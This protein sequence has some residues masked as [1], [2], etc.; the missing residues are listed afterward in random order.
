MVF[1]ALDIGNSAVKGGIFR[2]G[3]IEHI[4]HVDVVVTEP[5]SEAAV[6]TWTRALREHVSDVSVDRVGVASVVPEVAPVAE[7]A[8]RDL[9]GA[10]V[11][12]V[13][14]DADLPFRLAYETPQTLGADRLAAAAAGDDDVG[15]A[16]RRLHELDVHR[17]DG[18]F[19]LSEDALDG[20]A[21]VLDVAADATHQANVVGRVDVDLDVH[22]LFEL[23]LGQ[24]QDA[25]DDHDRPR[26]HGLGL[27]FAAVRGK[28]VDRLLDGLSVH[29]TIEVLPH[30]LGVERIG[31]IKVE[32]LALLRGMVGQVFVVGVVV[33]DRDLVGPKLV[34]DPV[35]HRRFARP[36]P[37]GNS[38][39]NGGMHGARLVSDVCENDDTMACNTMACKSM[40]CR[41]MACEREI[42]N[43]ESGPR[44]TDETQPSS[45]RT[46][47]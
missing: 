40:A 13:D 1:L 15:L 37:A 30:Q 35:E 43:L 17:P 33:E 29:Q 39:D 27:V 7:A 11:G 38:D 3:T 14:T 18:A 46:L 25:L 23:P 20:P 36:G 26:L 6:G 4:F 31:M 8:L 19:V 10:E 47:H 9:T 2:D 44:S 32:R 41:S 24:H 22:R 28:V 5:S 12:T 45:L 16:L 42:R 34:D 21:A